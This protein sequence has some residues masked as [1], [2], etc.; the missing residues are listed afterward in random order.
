MSDY[1]PPLP[2][3]IPPI[4]PIFNEINW[5]TTQEP[6]GG[7]GGAQGPA[8]VQGRQGP[9]GLGAT[10]PT[11]T[12]PLFTT[13]VFLA[14]NAGEV[15]QATY[16]IAI[17]YQAGV[18]YQAQNGIALGKFA[19]ETGQGSSAIAIGVGAGNDT[20]GTN[21][22]A[23]GTD[24]GNALQ[25]DYSVALGAFSGAP[26][27][28]AP[29]SA[30][31]NAT[32]NFL[33]AGTTGFFMAP[34]RPNIV[35]SGSYLMYDT[36]TNEIT[37]QM[38]PIRIGS[39]AGFTNQG[40][41]AVAIGDACG[42]INQG[43]NAVAIG[44]T[45]GESYQGSGA[46]AVGQIAGFTGQGQYAIS[47]GANAGY[48]TQGPEAIAIGRESGNL[49]QKDGAVAIGYG[50]AYHNQG[51]SAIAIG[52]F[53]VAIANF[54]GDNAIAIGSSA[55]CNYQEPYGIA[56]G[57]QAAYAGQQGEAIAIGK[58]AGGAGS[59]N[60]QEFGAVAIGT[61][62]G[63]DAI[64]VTAQGAY[65]VAVGY[66]S[67]N[68]AGNAPYSIFLNATGAP[69]AGQVGTT[70]FWVAPIRNNNGPQGLYYND[71]TSEITW[72]ALGQGPQGA[73]GV[74]GSLA[75]GTRV[76]S[77]TIA[78][79]AG[80]FF[81]GV[82]GIAVGQYGGHTAQGDFGVAV[83]YQAGM[84][85]QGSQGIAVGFQAGSTAQQNFG[86]AL[87]SFAG[88]TAQGFQAVAIGRN[89]AVVNQ[90]NNSIAIGLEAGQVT[91]GFSAIAIGRGA[92][93]TGSK[94]Y[95]TAIG[96]FTQ[97]SNG[98]D[99]GVAVGFQSGQTN[100]GNYAVGIGYTAG[101][102]NQS[103]GAIAIGYNTASSNQGT[104]AIA[105]GQDCARTSQANGAIAIGKSSGDTSQGINAIAIGEASGNTSQ[106]TYGVAMGYF[107]GTNRQQTNSV[108]IGTFAGGYFQGLN[109][110]AI[111]Y[112]AGFTGQGAYSVA[113]GHL[114]GSTSQASNSI[115][116]NAT[117]IGVTG[118]ATGFYLS[119]IRN[120]AT[121]LTGG[122]GSTATNWT[123]F[124]NLLTYDTSTKEIQYLSGIVQTQEDLSVY[125]GFGANI[126]F[127]SVVA[128]RGN[129]ANVS[130]TGIT[131]PLWFS[132]M[133][134]SG[135]YM[136]VGAGNFPSTTNSVWKSSDYGRTWS[137]AVASVFG[138]GGAISG[139][140]QY[141]LAGNGFV[142][143]YRSA[144]FGATWALVPSLSSTLVNSCF[145]SENGKY[146]IAVTGQITSLLRQSDDYGASWIVAPLPASAAGIYGC[147]MS[148]DGRYRL[149]FPDTR[150][151]ANVF[152]FSNNYGTSYSPLT[153]IPVPTGNW[154]LRGQ[155]SYNGQYW[156][157]IAYQ[158]SNIRISRDYGTTWTTVTPSASQLDS[159]AMSASGQYIVVS[160]STGL[161]FLSNDYGAT[162]SPLFKHPNA[163]H[164]KGLSI[165]NNGQLVLCAGN[166]TNTTLCQA[167]MF[168]DP[169]AIGTLAGATGQ[170]MGSV[171]IGYQAGQTVQAANS[172]A[173]GF[174]AGMSGQAS[175]SVAL[176]SL[177]GHWSQGS[178]SVAIGT[179]AGNTGQGQF[180]IA[181]GYY[182]GA[183]AQPAN[184][185]VFNATST[186]LTAGGTGF[187][188]K[189]VEQGP[190]GNR[191]LAY[192]TTTG[193]VFHTARSLYAQY[194]DSS[195]QANSGATGNTVTFNTIDMESGISLGSSSQIT[196]S[197][198]GY[199]AI[200]YSL[201]FT[202]TTNTEQYIDV[203]FEK[204]G[205]TILPNTNS[206]FGIV[207][208]Q[209]A[210]DGRLIASSTFFFYLV[211]NDYLIIRWFCSDTGVDLDAIPAGAYTPASPSAIV[212]IHLISS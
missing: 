101:Q 194:Q 211:Q 199:Y 80:E 28:Q 197:E 102:V 179:G 69:L 109:S 96:A 128:G 83:G 162:F 35:G 17:G 42:V 5:I 40:N 22:V 174:K 86:I 152:Y 114:A 37:S 200:Q 119:P 141:Q 193:H 138:F 205:T 120:G 84:S 156:A 97:L 147:A 209:N 3:P 204:N 31:I 9:Q 68:G 24:A 168:T 188:M 75:L 177:A 153:T 107:A 117:P 34:I 90:G 87:G 41:N 161:V 21:A 92:Q 10:G 180:S 60:F 29:F 122:V 64:N 33:N 145:I 99:F 118:G 49:N 212:N 15:S 175:S 8:G 191:M 50:A 173:I 11:G 52:K 32:G 4:P 39:A 198:T 203:W 158:Q 82:Q 45:A 125:S 176:G 81:Q 165:N 108:G 129:T 91:Q 182:A 2:P 56:I 74:Q 148:G 30:V 104:S 16:G 207:K 65:S 169:I 53:A 62:A 121:G 151:T 187:Y 66:Q 7:G 98:G 1:N 150:Y 185:I 88:G 166:S 18:Y 48:D 160:N 183:T 167:D 57:Y 149:T 186:G 126:G 89:S 85:I 155:I 54:Q 58:F 127:N 146:Q 106:Q 46:I 163:L 115:V 95:A 110:V 178:N 195:D 77:Q 23:I 136:L 190:T 140:G 159:L 202:N 51:D 70:G 132:S 189:P 61:E 201:Q 73:Q 78:S 47:V 76:N 14:S 63:K 67:N 133:S 12:Y 170:T 27:G 105:L 116:I 184:S 208:N 71:T 93:R 130:L 137:V 171:A 103:G 172:V 13:N 154:Y 19:G 143:T 112:Q 79:G 111:G 43:N 144:D 36:A 196:V 206:E 44:Y 123:G 55:V 113:I 26:S 135:K 94:Q 124:N 192:N 100:Q 131:Q 38:N 20:Q 181:M 25:G 72:G 139:N 134:N 164:D 59:S 210:I 142:A 6:I 157:L